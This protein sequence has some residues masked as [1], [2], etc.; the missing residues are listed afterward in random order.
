MRIKADIGE[1]KHSGLFKE[2]TLNRGHLH[3]RHDEPHARRCLPAPVAP[4]LLGLSRITE[5]SLSI[6]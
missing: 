5:I 4:G 2:V 3:L 1:R 6:P